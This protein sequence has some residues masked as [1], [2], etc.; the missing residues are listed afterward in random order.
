M[1]PAACLLVTRSDCGNLSSQ[2]THCRPSPE[3]HH[4]RCKY[5]SLSASMKLLDNM[6]ILKVHRS[7]MSHFS[8]SSNKPVR[9]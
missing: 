7:V 4:S 6:C 3:A 8:D 9:R 2:I 1:L 5:N